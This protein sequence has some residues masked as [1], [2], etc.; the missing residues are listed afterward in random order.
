MRVQVYRVAT[1][2][3]LLAAAAF[4]QQAGEVLEVFH[5]TNATGQQGM[6]EIGNAVRTVL[7]LPQ[8][9]VQMDARTLTVQAAPSN[10]ALAQWLFQEMDTPAAPPP[11][12]LQVD[13]NPELTGGADQMRIFRLAHTDAAQAYQEMLNATRTIPEI[14]KVFP[15]T[16][17]W[18]MAVRG[19]QDQ[20]NIAEWLLRQFDQP[21]TPLGQPRAE[22]NYSGID[23]AGFQTRVLYFAHATSPQSFQEVVNAIRTI[24]ELTKVFPITAQHAV[25]IRGTADRVAL[26]E[27]LLALLDK[28][29]PEPAAVASAIH[30][31]RPGADDAQVFFLAG[32]VTTQGFQ[33]AVHSLRTMLQILRVF[34]CTASRA[35][36]LRGTPDQLAQAQRILR[37]TGLL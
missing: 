28:A 11:P 26:A 1:V 30:E 16:R 20:L 24:P 4:A 29:G 3:S 17:T 33:D 31:V 9:S 5:F 8:V 37:D 32:S 35:L 27:W 2:L 22:A 7:E 21:A 19:S 6:Q 14:T 18:S 34:P 13:R 25:S 12:A 36:S 10:L 15:S 23:P